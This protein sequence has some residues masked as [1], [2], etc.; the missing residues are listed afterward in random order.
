MRLQIIVSRAPTYNLGLQTCHQ[1]AHKVQ[2]SS[3]LNFYNAVYLVSHK[4]LLDLGLGCGDAGQTLRG[5]EFQT[6]LLFFNLQCHLTCVCR[7]AQNQAVSR[8]VRNWVRTCSPASEAKTRLSI[9]ISITKKSPMDLN[10][11]IVKV[12]AY[13]ILTTL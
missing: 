6:H 4:I 5:S 2:P 13:L 12:R 1:F 8:P 7:Q 3:F 11:L 9:L 10:F